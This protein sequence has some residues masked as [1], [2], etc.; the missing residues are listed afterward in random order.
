ML[1]LL[2]TRKVEATNEKSYIFESFL[3]L[4]KKNLKILYHMPFKILYLVSESYQVMNPFGFKL[5]FLEFPRTTVQLYP[6]KFYHQHSLLFQLLK[7][8]WN[9]KRTY[10]YFYIQKGTSLYRGSDY[11]ACAAVNNTVWL[12]VFKKYLSPCEQSE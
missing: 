2:W 8:D 1:Y 4:R 12:A 11:T 3:Q 7:L 10:I 5:V 9:L 6:F